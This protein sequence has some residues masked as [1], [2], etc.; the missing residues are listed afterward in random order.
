MPLASKLVEII[1]VQASVDRKRS[2]SHNPELNSLVTLV[3]LCLRYVD[4]NDFIRPAQATEL[5]ALYLKLFGVIA[6]ISDDIV[7]VRLFAEYVQRLL[8]SSLGPS[9]S[10]ENSSQAPNYLREV[11]SNPL[12]ISR[13][14]SQSQTDTTRTRLIAAVCRLLSKQLQISHQLLI[15]SS[16]MLP[17]D[18][19]RSTENLDLLDTSIGGPVD[20]LGS[21]DD[22]ADDSVLHLDVFSLLGPFSGGDMSNLSPWALYYDSHTPFKQTAHKVRQILSKEESTDPHSL[23]KLKEEYITLLGCV[24]P[25]ID[26]AL[27]VIQK[28]AR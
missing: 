14:K 1:E 2:V 21:A 18:M 24:I 10:A 15:E 17:D 25:V 22:Q 3:L 26:H 23:M 13:L 19:K 16:S 7:Q 6:Y 5:L 27:T 4:H 28:F 20:L 11:L 9:N 12:I 8:A